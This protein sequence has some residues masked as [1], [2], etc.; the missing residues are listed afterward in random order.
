MSLRIGEYKLSLVAA[1]LPPLIQPL[2]ASTRRLPLPTLK[3]LNAPG[4]RPPTGRPIAFLAFYNDFRL[5][6]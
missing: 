2:T 6:D 1:A 3:R 4:A 5:L